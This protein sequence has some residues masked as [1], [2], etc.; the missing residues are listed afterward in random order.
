NYWFE[1]TA[2][3]L[4]NHCTGVG[5]NELGLEHEVV[6]A[7]QGRSTIVRKADRID[8][9]CVV[10]GHLAGSGWKEYTESG[11]LAGESLPA[12]LRRG[13]PLPEP[14]FT[15][16]AKHDSGHDMNISLSELAARAGT[17]RAQRLEAASMNLF[18]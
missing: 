11:T 13:D 10:R 12:G 4:P 3:L 5:L 1:R 15:P 7:L 14:R 6:E 9:E 2:D 17:D 8:F 18:R 16:A